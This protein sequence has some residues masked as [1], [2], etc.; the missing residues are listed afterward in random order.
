MDR[1]C[2]KWRTI[3]QLVVAH[4][5]FSRQE[6]KAL[7]SFVIFSSLTTPST[8]D[9]AADAV[10][11][12]LRCD[13]SDARGRGDRELQRPRQAYSVGVLLGHPCR[14]NS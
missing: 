3:A 10:I 2:Y 9:A 6:T 4:A 5:D 1:P 7:T 14:R 12:T 11:I 13:T 8:E